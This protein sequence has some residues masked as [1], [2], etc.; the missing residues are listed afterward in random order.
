MAQAYFLI[1]GLIAGPEAKESI[2]EG[3]L[4]LLKKTFGRLTE[5]PVMQPLGSPAF[6]KSVHLCWLWSVLTRR[7]LPFVSAPY[8]WTV[9]NGPMLSGDIN[10]IYLCTRNERGLLSE[11]AL[12]FDEREA[13]CAALTPVLLKSG[14]VL[15]R[16]DPHLYLTRKKRFAAAAAPFEVV[17]TQEGGAGRW[18][19]GE[20]KA[21]AL[22]LIATCEEALSSIKSPAQ[23]VWIC[24][25][26]G[27]F[28]YVYPPTKIRGVLTD[29]EAVKGWALAAGILVQRI[30]PVSKAQ[31]WPEEAPN[32]ECIALIEDL[33]EAWLAH[34]WAAWEKAL[35]AVCTR[36]E[37]L[38]EAAR[39]K[40]CDA[41]LIVGTGEGFAVSCSRRLSAA[42]SLLARFT[43]TAF[44]P[45]GILFLEN[46][47]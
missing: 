41:A 30:A 11:A 14:F 27:A 19:E 37:V 26:G 33:Y 34:D 43:G 28:D 39:K 22:E 35:P 5:A 42:R 10:A 17:Q 32:G 18:I 3:S 40:G 12:T 25:G 9:Q 15:Q 7:A 45:A 31:N 29:N 6:A 44:N 36:I 2:S 8:A 21:A 46:D 23:T 13:A 4:E 20:E 16:W 24:G 47:Q 38:S 1:P